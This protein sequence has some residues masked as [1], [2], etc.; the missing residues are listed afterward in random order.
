MKIYMCVDMDPSDM[1]ILLMVARQENMP[2]DAVVKTAIA[3]YVALKLAPRQ[4]ATTA[5]GEK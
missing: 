2:V 3:Q 1:M 5:G 4:T